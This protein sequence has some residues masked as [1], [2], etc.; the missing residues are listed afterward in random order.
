M[1]RGGV[2]LEVLISIVIFVGAAGFCIRATTDALD[3]LDRDHRRLMAADLARTAM[4]GLAAGRLTLADFREGVVRGEDPDD[5]Q[6]LTQGRWRFDLTTGPSGRPPLSLLTLTV[7]EESD[8]E[9]PVQFTLRELVTLR[10][11]ASDAWQEDDLLQD[12]PVRPAELGVT[13]P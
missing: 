5:E 6:L 1:T 9:S 12:L 7:I 10:E 8:R 3:A 13:P 2:L 11:Q 4:S